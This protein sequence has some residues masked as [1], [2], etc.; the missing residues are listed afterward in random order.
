M[1]LATA[2]AVVWKLWASV[3]AST[4]TL[5]LGALPLVG[6]GAPRRYVAEE[7]IQG[8]GDTVSLPDT[9]TAFWIS[10]SA[11]DWRAGVALHAGLLPHVAFGQQVAAVDHGASA[12]AAAQA[13]ARV[14]GV[15]LQIHG[16][17]GVIRRGGV[18]DVVLR[19]AQGIL[20]SVQRAG[21]SDQGGV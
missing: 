9:G 15:G 19:D 13:R 5:L 10:V 6:A 14:E 3:P 8:G 7:R 1:R 21:S 16:L 11:L 17:I 20:E 4:I 18:V 2:A 12:N